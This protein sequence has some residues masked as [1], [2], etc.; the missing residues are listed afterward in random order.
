MGFSVLFQSTDRRNLEN[1]K[2]SLVLPLKNQMQ[3]GQS[4]CSFFI[5]AVLHVVLTVFP[6]IFKTIGKRFLWWFL[7]TFHI[8]AE[9]ISPLILSR[10]FQIWYGIRFILLLP[11]NFSM[12][13]IVSVTLCIITHTL[14][15]I[16]LYYRQHRDSNS[17]LFKWLPRKHI[18][19]ERSLRLSAEG[20]Y[21]WYYFCFQQQNTKRKL[22]LKNSVLYSSSIIV[23]PGSASSSLVCVE[24]STND[25]AALV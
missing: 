16:S 19:L 2:Q 7:D 4:F 5:T 18:T 20:F 8:I 3:P 1:L 22:F 14:I 15:C 6:S 9:E 10:Y 13:N 12:C 11:I 25:R 23:F 17:E 24:E 21:N